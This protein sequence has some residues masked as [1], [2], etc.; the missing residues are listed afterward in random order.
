[1]PTIKITD[2]AAEP[3][4]LAEAKA[5][6][7]EDLADAGNDAYITGLITVVRQA[8]EERLQRTLLTSTW[9]RSD[10]GFTRGCIPLL[11]PR[12]QSITWLKYVAED[13]T[14]TT[15]DPAAYELEATHEPGLLLPAYGLAWPAARARPGA[16]KVQ[17]KAGYGDTADSLPKP[18]V[19]WMLLA[20]T[21]LYENRARSSERPVL[22]QDFA[23]GLINSF[24]I[25]SI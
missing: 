22:P 4:T 9:Q 12:I 16:V 21:D 17:Y 24:E 7:R 6:L 19:Q 5:H 20:L 11:F 23:D 15:L 13:G 18:I 3:I 1:M 8:A 10:A 2:A 25:R 14:L